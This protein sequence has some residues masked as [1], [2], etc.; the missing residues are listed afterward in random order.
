MGPP[1]GGRV[2]GREGK[3]TE[4]PAAPNLDWVTHGLSQG[5]TG[6]V[7]IHEGPLRKTSLKTAQVESLL[8]GSHW[9]PALGL[10]LIPGLEQS[11]VIP[12]LRGK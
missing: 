2:L 9:S 7:F 1:V 12:C 5:D 10:R 8:C 6:A 11:F 3:P 4:E